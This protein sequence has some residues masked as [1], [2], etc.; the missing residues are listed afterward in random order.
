MSFPL[1]PVPNSWRPVV[2]QARPTSSTVSSRLNPDYAEAWK[3]PLMS[4]AEVRQDLR[5]CTEVFYSASQGRH[6]DLDLGVDQG[7]NGRQ[8]SGGGY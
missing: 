4:D 1:K 3:Y 7:G 5:I 8:T 6:G 2:K